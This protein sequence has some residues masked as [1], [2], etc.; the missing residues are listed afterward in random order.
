MTIINLL[1][2]YHM[3][4]DNDKPTE[5]AKFRKKKKARKQSPTGK[6]TAGGNEGT[7]NTNDSNGGV[8]ENTPKITPGQLEEF[9]FRYLESGNPGVLPYG[10]DPS[11][12]HG[13]YDVWTYWDKDSTDP[14]IVRVDQ[15]AGIAKEI[16]LTKMVGIIQ[17]CLSRFANPEHL[18]GKY[19]LSNSQCVNLAKRL[20]ASGR[21]LSRWPDPIG[22]KSSLGLF[23]K[24]HDFDPADSATPADFPTINLNL[25]NMTN[26]RNF[27]ERVG[28]IYFKEADRK[29]GVYLVGEG[30]GGK[31]A[32]AKLLTELAGGPEGVAMVNMQVYS[33]FG[34]DPLVDKRIWLAEELPPQFYKNGKHKILTGG[35]AVQINRKGERQFNAYLTGMLF[36]FSN[37]PPELVDDSG[38]RN[39]IIICEVGTIPE[40]LRLPKDETQRRMR[41]ELPYFIRYCIDLYLKVGGNGTLTPDTTEKVEALISESEEDV[42][43]IFDKYFVEDLTK[44]GKNAVISCPIF[45]DFWE[46]ICQENPAFARSQG[47]KP[48]NFRKYIAK[49]LGRQ[50]HVIRCRGHEGQM[51]AGLAFKKRQ[52]CTP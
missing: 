23:F 17:N 32:L 52:P 5:L 44:L 9:L 2:G 8:G 37:E 50:N 12:V 45:N 43:S 41:A 40:K 3:S 19:C 25:Q 30:D 27:C 35:A 34:L 28:S 24:R 7:E 38:L 31:T 20:I 42:A 48:T 47:F 11:M 18:S 21:T 22:F 10:C 26:S 39:R 6:T 13:K 4:N 16:G 46:V 36:A 14:R 15:E 49:R 33:S 29:Q 1:E 51:Y